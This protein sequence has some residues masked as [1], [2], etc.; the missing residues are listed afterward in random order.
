MTGSVG[1][2]GEVF[3]TQ[4]SLCSKIRRFREGGMVGLKV[5]GKVDGI[6]WREL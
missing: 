5:R 3:G 6:K 4:W 2:R 1:R